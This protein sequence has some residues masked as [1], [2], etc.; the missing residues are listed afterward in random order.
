MSRVIAAQLVP[1]SGEQ[2]ALESVAVA[3]VMRGLCSETCMT[4]RYRNLEAIAI[5]AVYTFP[6]PLDAVLLELALDLNGRTLTG[7]VSPRR[8]AEE[9]YEEAIASGDSAVLLR[10]VEPGI[11]SVSVG[12]ILPGEQVTVRY[13]YAQLHA[14]QGE[15]VRFQLPTTIA[16]R[17]GDPRVRGYMPHEVPAHALSVDY[18]FTLELRVEGL[19][20]GADVQ[21]PTHPV[22]IEQ[23]G[24]ARVFRLAGG[25]ALMDRDFVLILKAARGSEPVGYWAGDGDGVAALATFQPGY[26]GEPASTP[27][28]VKLVVD[29][30][31]S[32]GGDSIRQAKAAVDDIL[33]SL[34]PE[35]RFNITAFGS[36][37]RL[38]FA[39]PK[40][41]RGRHLQVARAF[42]AQMDANLGGT[43]IGEALR[44][45]YKADTD[46]ETT[47]DVL[48]I[49]DGEIWNADTVI[50]EARHSGH[51][52]F[53]VG[54]GSA[55]SEGFVREIAATTGGACELISPRERMAE[56]IVRHFSRIR[57]PRAAVVE[58][59]WPSEPRFQAPELPPGVYAGDTLHLFARLTEA[60]TAPVVLHLVFSDGRTMTQ[61]LAL[62]PID[63]NDG[64]RATLPR[65]AANT[66][67]AALSDVDAQ[68]IAVD[69]QL[70]T[71]QTSCVLVYDREA[72]NAVDDLP[73]LRQVP[74]MLAAGWGGTGSVAGDPTD[75]PMILAHCVEAI[76][77]DVLEVNDGG[78]AD[79]EVPAFLRRA[80]EPETPRRSPKGFARRLKAKRSATPLET[81][82][83][84]PFGI[85]AALQAHGIRSLEQLTALTERA[86]LAIGELDA[87]D[88]A[89]IIRALQERGLGLAQS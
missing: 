85:L 82:D 7:V 8:A 49:T 42:L 33:A 65:L 4:Q 14:W 36:H 23:R 73:A 64:F 38:L 70:V 35:D 24:D 78:D 59:Q 87:E 48:L 66:R 25:T 15:S 60:P 30:S 46:R 32:M 86:L 52:V 67:I 3:S 81:L 5:E 57:Q 45:T 58:V 44:A 18:G 54:V 26:P 68:R 61:T 29:C 16:P 55:V 12:N 77:G 34:N 89:A 31:G 76:A 83:G 63:E 11:Y 50:E 53:S 75:A 17:Y 74:Q 43:E 71:D 40:P 22:G 6:L 72:D 56:H 27:R 37:H 13:R 21:C 47:A 39:A 41:A 28:V 79:F 19:L 80:A 84:L 2:I 10:Q 1:E 88:V 9:T 62:S 20:A 51:R 69:Y